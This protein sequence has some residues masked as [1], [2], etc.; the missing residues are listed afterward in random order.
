MPEYVGPLT[1]HPARVSFTWYFGLILVGGFVLSQ[2]V[3][4]ASGR[5]PVSWVDSLFT[6]T[7]ATCVTGLA[8]R[9]TGNDFSVLGQ[10]VILAL[11]QLGGI[12]IMTVTTYITFQ[13][14]GRQSLRHRMILS[15]TL[16]AAE[17][18]DLRS[19][20]RRVLKLTVAV[21]GVGVT[22]LFARFLFDLPPG[23]ALWHAVFHAISAY[24][25]AGF[26]LYDDNLTRYD[27]D[28]IVNGTVMALIVIGGIGYPV[29]LDLLHHR[30]LP[31]RDLWDHL[32]LHSKIMLLGTALL[33]VVGTAAVL[34]LEWD[35]VLHGR[36]WPERILVSLFHSIST[37]TAGF[38]SVDL[39]SMTN[40]TLFITM[41]LMMIGAGPCSTGGGVKVTTFMLLA[42]H[43]WSSFRG[44]ARLNWFRR[45]APQEVVNR[46]V[47]TVLVFSVVSVLALVALLT[48]EQSGKPHVESGALF[49]DAAFET[50]SA[51][52]TVGL[53]TGL[54][55]RLTSAGKVIVIVLMFLGRLGPITAFAALARTRRDHGLQYVHD[56]PLF[57]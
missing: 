5:A 56:A 12:G 41:L 46:A 49:L 17:E 7:S 19:V 4:H 11:I 33:I 2:P 36:P 3:C 15:E 57:G 39:A 55:P 6:A 48:I 31:W 51:L 40:A 21:E 24:C 14:G 30:K 25:N 27:A 18:S 23:A 54:T 35:G 20:L 43:A 1:Q 13:L 34:V 16:G 37:R 28:P 45:T 9:S 29:I 8:V 50:V 22:L 47:A 32:T 42:A 53:S 10:L 44:Y 26:G 52:G 38:N